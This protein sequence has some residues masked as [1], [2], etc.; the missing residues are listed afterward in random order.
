MRAVRRIWTKDSTL[1]SETSEPR[2]IG[3]IGGTW[4]YIGNK[5]LGIAQGNPAHAGMD[6]GERRPP[7]TVKFIVLG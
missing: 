6:L 3:K 7:T 4:E 2:K 5:F 1:K